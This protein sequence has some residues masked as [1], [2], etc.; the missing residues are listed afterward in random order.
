MGPKMRF[1]T[2][3]QN[4]ISGTFLIFGIKL[5][6]HEVLKLRKIIFWKNFCFKVSGPK[7]VPNG[8]R[9]KFLSSDKN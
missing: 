8:P 4:S 7:V 9:M 2:Y 6:Q 1:L 3:Y 5:Q